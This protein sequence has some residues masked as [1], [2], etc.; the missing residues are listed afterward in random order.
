[1]GYTLP[2]GMS[3]VPVG[4]KE[5]RKMKKNFNLVFEIVSPKLKTIVSV[6]SLKFFEEKTYLIFYAHIFFKN[7][8]KYYLF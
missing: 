8:L 3:Y 4:I 1:M 2:E 7:H 6:A 5:T